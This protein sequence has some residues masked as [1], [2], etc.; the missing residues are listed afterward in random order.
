M[1]DY[2]KYTDYIDKMNQMIKELLHDV[3]CKIED[4]AVEIG[5]QIK[6]MHSAGV[7]HKNEASKIFNKLSKQGGELSSLSTDYETKL[8]EIIDVCEDKVC[9]KNEKENK[10]DS[11]KMKNVMTKYLTNLNF[12][13]EKLNSEHDDLIDGIYPL[14]VSLQFHDAVRQRVERASQ[15]ISFFES[16]I[17]ESDEINE[18]S[19]GKELFDIVR[20]PEEFKIISKIWNIDYEPNDFEDED[21]TLF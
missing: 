19:F 8:E 17:E 13:H 4:R 18:Q 6:T 1:K 20:D 16:K 9:I 7:N 2:K 5:D 3:A 11:K 15:C 10:L 12:N 21:V 14:V